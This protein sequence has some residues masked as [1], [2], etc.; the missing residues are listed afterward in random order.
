M[1]PPLVAIIYNPK[2]G[3]YSRA[4]IKALGVAFEQL[5][6]RVVAS[7]TTPEM[8]EIGSDVDRVCVVGGD[9]TVRQ[10]VEALRVARRAMPLSIDP[11]GTV[12]LLSMEA[13]RDLSPRA[14]AMRLLGEAH[15]LQY[16]VA[17][18][19]TIFLA[20]A[21]VGPEAW[22]VEHVST[23]LK[24]GIGRLAYAAALVPFLVR[25]RRFPIRLDIGDRAIACEAFYVAKGRYFAGKWM[26]S[27]QADLCR[28]EMRLVVLKTARRRDMLRFWMR[29]LLHRAIE[30]LPFVEVI[31]CTEFR[32][33]ASLPL[34][35][36]ADGDIVTSLP[37]RFALIPTPIAVA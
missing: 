27:P 25:W 30:D 12:N 20:C 10:V 13:P 36:Q 17:I 16:G 7:P 1:R 33:S 21:S 19:D 5:G 2:S 34:A 18:N 29:L 35:V 8:V 28:P 14:L 15:R 26:L 9:G 4:R 24:R 22:A 31:V 3:S 37:A 23:G 11:C 6:A 32:A